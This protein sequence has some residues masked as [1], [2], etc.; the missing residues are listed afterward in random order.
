MSDKLVKT[1]D[2]KRN[3]YE[4]YKRDGGMFGSSD[5]VVRKDG[6]YLSSHKYLDDAVAKAK[7]DGG[8]A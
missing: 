5:F 7:K 8:V 6:Q 1:I 4:I 3:V 2:G